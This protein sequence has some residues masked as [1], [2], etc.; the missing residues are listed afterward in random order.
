MAQVDSAKQTCLDGRGRSD[1][2]PRSDA[3]LSPPQLESER[4][5]SRLYRLALVATDSDV[6][7]RRRR[8]HRR[9]ELRYGHHPRHK[10]EAEWGAAQSPVGAYMDHG[11][12]CDPTGH[13]VLGP[14]SPPPCTILQCARLHTDR[15]AADDDLRRQRSQPV[16]PLRWAPVGRVRSRANGP[17][18]HD[19]DERD[20][21]APAWGGRRC[22]GVG[23]GIWNGQSWQYL[24]YLRAIRGLA[25]RREAW[26]K[27][28]S[29][30]HPG[31]GGD[32][33]FFHL[34]CCGHD[35]VVEVC[36]EWAEGQTDQ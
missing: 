10:R 11:P 2:L 9:A 3:S 35:A 25:E 5:P 32:I 18:H 36:R 13:P 26:K 30:E 33:V 1:T 28:V 6:L 4:S 23:A 29:E 15:R 22:C 8:R 34:E 20:L 19:V 16:A 14:L 21:P 24:D 12:D 17:H 27:A 7:W 31:D